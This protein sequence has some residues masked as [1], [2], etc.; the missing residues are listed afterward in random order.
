MT[1]GNGTTETGLETV[2]NGPAPHPMHDENG[3]FVK[4]NPG[5]P[6]RP[7]GS[8]DPICAARNEARKQGKDLGVMVGKAVLTLLERAADPDDRA[9]PASAK[10]AFDRVCGIL[11]RFGGTGDV[12]IDNRSVNI[13]TPTLPEGVDE[14]VWLEGLLRRLGTSEDGG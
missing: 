6:G 14:R 10:I 1:E 7:R 9:G 4:G 12:N 3:K 5:G 13:G 8:V 11:E 2:E